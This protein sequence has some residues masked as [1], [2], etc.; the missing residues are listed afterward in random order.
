MPVPMREAGLP[1]GRSW[2]PSQVVR[3]SQVERLRRAVIAAVFQWHE[4][5]DLGALDVRLK[6]GEHRG[7]DGAGRRHRQHGDAHEWVSQ[8]R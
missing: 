8:R 3:A 6:V 5:A 2:L 7:E 4:A 1:R